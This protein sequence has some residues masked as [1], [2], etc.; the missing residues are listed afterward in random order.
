MRRE[1]ASGDRDDE[2]GRRLA[3]LLSAQHVTVRGRQIVYW[4][5]GAG[6]PIVLVHGLGGSS[7]CWWLAVDALAAR[8]RVYLVDLPGFGSLRRL[9][10]EFVLADGAEWLREWMTAAAIERGDLV[11]HSMGGYLAL[12]LAAMEPARVRRLVLVAPAGIPTGRSLWRHVLGLPR[13]WRQTTL[14]TLRLAATDALRTHPALVWRV[15]RALVTEDIVPLLCS[16]RAPAL[17][18]WGH[19]DPLIPA[20]AAAVLRAE[21]RDAR[22]VLIE[23]AGHMPMITHAAEF[24]AALV[25]FLGE[26]VAEIPARLSA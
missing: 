21:L 11:G 5:A 10:R 9:Y 4:S 23:R 17:L 26:E 14:S 25:A 6:P 3:P 8:H 12:R 15:A 24:T 22:L 13:H 20:A 19:E 18:V 7:R 2:P 1:G 16:V